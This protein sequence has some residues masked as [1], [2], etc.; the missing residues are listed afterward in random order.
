M[1]ELVRSE[2]K[3]RIG[4]FVHM[5]PNRGGSYQYVEFIFDAFTSCLDKYNVE[6]VYVENGW[7]E[8]LQQEYPFFSAQQIDFRYDRIVDDLDS[9]GFDYIF[10]PTYGVDHY[11]ELALK[12]PLI[13]VIHDLMYYYQPRGSM[14]TCKESSYLYQGQCR[15]SIGIF[16]DSNLGKQHCMEALGHMY[17][18]KIY[19]LPFRAPNYLFRDETRT[20]SLKNKKYIFYPAQLWSI[21]N[22]INIILAIY[23]LKQK[24]I[25]VNL[26]FT[27]KGGRDFEKICNYIHV[28]KLEDQIEII[29]Y[30]DGAAIKFL[31]AHARAAVMASYTGPTNIPPIEAMVMGCPIAVSD[32]FAM[33]EQ[34]GDAGLYFDPRFPEDIADVLEH[35]WVDDDLC[36][37]LSV[38]GRERAKIFSREV[39]NSRFQVAM[40]KMIDR[41]E[42]DTACLHDLVSVCKKYRR[43]YLYGAGEIGFLIGLFLSSKREIKLEGY[44]VSKYDNEQRELLGMPIYEFDAIKGNIRDALVVLAVNENHQKE[45]MDTNVSENAGRIYRTDN[46][47]KLE[48]WVNYVKTH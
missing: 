3:R 22:H 33:P 16:V 31:F 42:Q 30:Q 19:V 36:R 41:Y 11:F 44:I 2:E 29:D 37:R 12:T 32:I 6:V 15:R 47:H 17:E 24:G 21:K 7:R 28:L 9:F 25:L 10:L 4:I 20:V 43:I 40:K 35:L 46:R 23:V 48:A 39:F 45:I 26:L 1:G 38:L 18:E 34:V 8:I 14:W 5:Q 27:G 13:S